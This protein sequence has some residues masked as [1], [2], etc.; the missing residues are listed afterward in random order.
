MGREP[1]SVPP[2]FDAIRSKYLYSVS[3]CGIDYC[4]TVDRTK[5]KELQQKKTKKKTIIIII[6]ML[7]GCLSIH[8]YFSLFLFI[9]ESILFFFPTSCC[10]RVNDDTF[11]PILSPSNRRKYVYIKGK[12]HFAYFGGYRLVGRDW[13]SLSVCCFFSLLFF[14]LLFCCPTDSSSELLTQS[15]QCHTQ[16]IH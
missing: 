15:Y 9:V 7:H 16:N 1:Y 8:C 14:L 6:E 2:K 3:D 13:Q 11:S 12:F 4:L 10:S 5:P